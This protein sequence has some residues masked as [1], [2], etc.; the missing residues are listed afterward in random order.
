MSPSQGL[1]LTSSPG[2]LSDGNDREALKGLACCYK[3]ATGAL[4]HMTHTTSAARA[5][6]RRQERYLTFHNVL[7]EHILLNPTTPE[8]DSTL[9]QVGRTMYEFTTVVILKTTDASH[10]SS[11][12][13]STSSSV[14]RKNGWREVEYSASLAQRKDE[15]G[16]CNERDGSRRRRPCE[17]YL[18]SE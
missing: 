10:W 16:E 18:I 7:Q 14:R 6:L 8:R 5:K 17:I 4:M 15:G 2:G 11:L 3:K 9:C 13:P 12:A 1:V